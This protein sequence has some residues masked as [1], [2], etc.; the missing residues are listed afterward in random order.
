MTVAFTLE[1]ESGDAAITDNPQGEIVRILREMITAVECGLSYAVLHD[2][3]G[4][5]IGYC[6]LDIDEDEDRQP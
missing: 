4:N 3:N 1:V 6:S 5:R 2:S